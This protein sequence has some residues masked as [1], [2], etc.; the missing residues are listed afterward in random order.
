[1]T[2]TIAKTAI[3]LSQN[4]LGQAWDKLGQLMPTNPCNLIK[5]KAKA[6]I[7]EPRLS[8]AISIALTFANHTID[9]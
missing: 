3:C 1:M 9:C 5:R 4:S 2:V 7:S 8:H 6:T